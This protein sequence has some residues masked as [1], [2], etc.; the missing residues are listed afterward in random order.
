MYVVLIIYGLNYI[1]YNNIKTRTP[2]SNSTKS[3]VVSLT[4]F[5]IIAKYWF[6]LDTNSSVIYVSRIG[7]FLLELK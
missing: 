5:N 4:S 2:S 1:R 7:S 3:P 6:V